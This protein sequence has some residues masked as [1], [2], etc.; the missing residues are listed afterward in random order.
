MRRNLWSNISTPH[1]L[2]RHI[3][4]VSC[5]APFSKYTLRSSVDASSSHS[6][7]RNLLLASC[8]TVILPSFHSYPPRNRGVNP[9][10]SALFRL[11]LVPPR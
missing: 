11:W 5:L 1:R 3:Q 6:F 10:H 9:S 7:G 2:V 8:H 4:L